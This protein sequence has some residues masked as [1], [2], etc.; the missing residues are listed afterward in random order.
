MALIAVGCAL[1]DDPSKHACVLDQH[2]A[3]GRF[4]VQGRCMAS[5]PVPSA[6]GDA[7]A[8]APDTDASEL[9]DVPRA[10]SAD[11]DSSTPDS[12]GAPDGSPWDATAAT[13]ADGPPALGPDGCKAGEFRSEDRCVSA[14]VSVAVSNR[15]TCAVLRDGTAWCWGGHGILSRPDQVPG[16]RDAQTVAVGGFSSTSS[17]GNTCL[18]TRTEQ[19]LCWGEDLYGLVGD[20]DGPPPT[21][22]LPRPVVTANVKPLSGVRQV[23]LGTTF[24]CA[25]TASTLYCWGE[26]TRAQLGIPSGPGPGISQASG[27]GGPIYYRTFADAV[28]GVP[29]ATVGVGQYNAMSADGARVCGWGSSLPS[30]RFWP[31]T[32]DHTPPTCLTMAGVRQVGLG[33]RGACLLRDN[34]E[35]TCWGLDVGLFDPPGTRANILPAKQIAVGLAHVCALQ[36]DGRIYCWGQGNEGQLGNGPHPNMN[37]RFPENVKALGVDVTAI[38]SGRNANHTCAIKTDGSLWCWGRND[39]G[40]LGNMAAGP[41]PVGPVPVK[42]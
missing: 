21:F 23:T 33:D 24:G 3:V 41:R 29:A 26:N 42:W 16:I 12:A 8:A 37:V 5:A 2:C 9:A 27:G 34:G 10:G 30:T 36:N 40:Q 17:A 22:D 39:E 20:G 6:D 38:A 11:A 32:A 15:R 19:L 14:V 28:P 1:R 31:T 35:V 18:V 7:S 4:C 13:T 25:T